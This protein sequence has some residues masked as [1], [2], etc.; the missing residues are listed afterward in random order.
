MRRRGGLVGAALE[1]FDFLRLQ[2]CTWHLGHRAQ[3]YALAGQEPAVENGI[4]WVFNAEELSEATK[5]FRALCHKWEALALEAA[6]FEDPNLPEAI[7]PYA[8]TSVR[9]Q[10]AAIAEH[11]KLGI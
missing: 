3:E 4:H 7:N 11:H 1:V 6:A 10:T 8:T 5:R 2:R 9:L